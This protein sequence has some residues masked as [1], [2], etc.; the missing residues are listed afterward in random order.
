[1]PGFNTEEIQVSAEPR[2]LII[3]GSTSQANEKE[4]ESIFYR[5]ILAK[6]VF[7]SLDLPVEVDAASAEATLRDGI[8]KVTL[9]KLNASKPSLR[10]VTIWRARLLE[11][12]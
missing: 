6:D 10:C 8:L 1:M 9:P 3:S 12:R 5:E 2:R 4:T 7:R 11:R